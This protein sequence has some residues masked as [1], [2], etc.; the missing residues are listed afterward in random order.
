M[1]ANLRRLGVRGGKAMIFAAAAR[2]VLI[3][4]VLFVTAAGDQYSQEHA[5][6]STAAA[7]TRAVHS[8]IT[9]EHRC[10]LAPLADAIPQHAP[11]AVA[12]LPARAHDAAVSLTRLAL[13]S[14]CSVLAHG[15]GG[16]M[17]APKASAAGTERHQEPLL[18]GSVRARLGDSAD[19]LA[20]RLQ[21][22]PDN[23]TATPTQRGGV[24]GARMAL[25]ARDASRAEAR[26]T[27]APDCATHP[28]MA[29]TFDDGPVD[30][31]PA[32][33]DMLRS[34][35]V[36]ATFFVIGRHA[37]ARGDVLARMHA[38]GHAI[39]NHTYTHPTLTDLGTDAIR[40]ELQ[41][42]NNI[43]EAA[44]G[45]RPT[46]LRAP[47][48]AVNGD[49]ATIA[50]ELGLAIIHWSIDPQE[51]AFHDSGRTERAVLAEAQ[52]GSIVLSH[53]FVPSTA[54]VYG[55]V[56]DELRDRGFV[57][58]TVPDLLAGVEPGQWYDRGVPIET[59]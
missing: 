32:L 28:C 52:P 42:A 16:R 24:D 56:I 54:E 22:A 10:R 51:W 29:L 57:F 46:L 4:A 5:R 40:G 36:A 35:G 21:I 20:S 26:E 45:E 48:G 11:A 17:T 39:G 19:R 49:V 2:S 38:E 53:D 3:M 15:G 43:I 13:P 14:A 12:V 33:L 9:G 50:S 34:K 55:R 18:A 31:T 7:A 59:G 37:E 6:D 41:Q 25:S 1:Q 44:T 23:Q 27:S 58:V 30:T 47:Y 8:P